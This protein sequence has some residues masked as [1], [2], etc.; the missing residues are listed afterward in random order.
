MINE[1]KIK[2]YYG[3]WLEDGNTLQPH[4]P[5]IYETC[6]ALWKVYRAAKVY[7]SYNEHYAWEHCNLC[8]ALSAVSD[9][10]RGTTG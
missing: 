6:L 9:K 3:N 10:I 1:K 7:H 8:M 5:D 2:E 4:I